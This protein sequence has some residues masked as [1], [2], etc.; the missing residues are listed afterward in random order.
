VEEEE[1]LL[2]ER[3]RRPLS[4]AE[5][6]TVAAIA[7]DLGVPANSGRPIATEDLDCQV[8]WIDNVNKSYFA[9]QMFVKSK[10]KSV[11]NTCLR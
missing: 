1:P 11:P 9:G 4:R 6:D 7:G 10:S 8:G 3:L 5:H 2:P